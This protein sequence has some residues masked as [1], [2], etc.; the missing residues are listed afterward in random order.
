[1]RALI[2][3]PIVLFSLLFGGENITFDK[4][5]IL[6]L[7]S[8]HEVEKAID[9]YLKIY[10]IEKK[11]D[12]EVLEQMCLTLLE[13]GGS[14]PFPEDQLLTLF[15]IS[16]SQSSQSF[17]PF[18]DAAIRSPF[19]EVQA[20]ALQILSQTHEDKSDDIIA[21]GLKSNFLQ[22]R[23]ETLFH[24]I[25]RK[26]SNSLGQIESL[27]NL[28]PP[29]AKPFFV[30]FY[31]LHGSFEAIQILK[32]LLN[33]PDPSVR[34]TAILYSARYGRDDLLP[35]I[36]SALTHSDPLVKEAASFA[37]G[38]LKDLHSINHLKAA[39]NSPFPETKL[40]ALISLFHLGHTESSVEI[41]RLA[42]DGNLFAIHLLKEIPESTPLLEEL[43][44]SKDEAISLNATIALLHLKNPKA[45]PQLMN[46]LETNLD[47]TYFIPFTSPGRS[48]LAWKIAPPS[49]FKTPEQKNNLKAISLHFQ[50]ELLTRSLELPKENFLQIAKK[51]MQGKQTKLLPLLIRLLENESSEETKALLIEKAYAIDHPLLRSYCKLALYR[52]HINTFYRAEFLKW[53]A[54]Q[55]ATKMIEFR[56]MLERN[57]RD[58]KQKGDYTLSPEE[59]SGLFIESFDALASNH[60]PEGI[61]FLL[62]SLRD[63]HV[64]N[65]YAFAGLLLKS[66]H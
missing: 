47:V 17:L 18:L 2:F 43:L 21:T 46:L 61:E 38:Y 27:A 45:L 39:S 37:I 60:D 42:K 6:Y 23:F 13:I 30:E 14:S 15:G 48:L 19:P 55:K 16:L 36:R 44:L 53:L 41:C 26:T 57:A 65:R 31:A 63:G 66:I 8:I 10:K 35:N 58:D 5:H 7:M 52:M 4:R 59:I 32:Q 56:P 1:M 51:L 64:K 49:S 3:L 20:A 29:Q 33:D 22:I 40:A 62:E 24:L 34:I 11:H 50:E 9:E 28:L 54:H 25:H 12:F